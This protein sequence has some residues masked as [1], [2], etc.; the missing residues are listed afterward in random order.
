MTAA[1][2]LCAC[3]HVQEEQKEEQE[4]VAWQSQHAALG[5]MAGCAIK[6][7]LPAPHDLS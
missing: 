1:N 2:V 7:G 4:G 3:R 5:I 6:A